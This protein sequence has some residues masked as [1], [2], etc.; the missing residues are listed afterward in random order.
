DPEGGCG[1]GTSTFRT[2]VYGSGVDPSPAEVFARSLAAARGGTDGDHP[3]HGTSGLLGGLGVDGDLGGAVA[4]RVQQLVGVDH[5]HVVALRTAVDRFELRGGV[6]GAQ[7]VQH[8]GLGRDEDLL[9]VGGLRGVE[10]AAGGAHLDAILGDGAA[11]HEVEGGS[12]ATAFGVHVH[13][14][15]GLGLHSLSEGVAVDPGVHVALAHPHVDVLAAG[16][17]L[18]VGAEELVGKEEDL[19]L[20]GDGADHVGGVG[21]GAADVGLGLDRGGGVDVGD[22]HRTGVLGLP[23]AH[24]LGG[25]GVGQG[26]ARVGVGQQ[27]GLLRGEDLCGLGHEVHTAEDDGARLDTGG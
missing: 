10:H 27:D 2:H 21:G 5:L 16:G 11:A 8:A 26:A 7:L 9:G 12:G 17:A 20:L 23:V 14:R 18:D 3:F 4:Q 22:H 13:L 24:V 6:G 19:L 15:V 25:D 1:S